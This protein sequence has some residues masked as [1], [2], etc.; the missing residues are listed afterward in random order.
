[1]PRASLLIITVNSDINFLLDYHLP[2]IVAPNADLVVL[3]LMDN[4]GLIG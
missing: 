1:M 3:P 4:C 2:A